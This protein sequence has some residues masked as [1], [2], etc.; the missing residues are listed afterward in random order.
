VLRRLITLGG[1]AA[2]LSVFGCV[3]PLTYP[4]TPTPRSG[5][6]AATMAPQ[7][8][9]PVPP[10]SPS[11]SPP[12]HL[13]PKVLAAPP[14]TTEPTRVLEGEPTSTPTIVPAATR[15][16]RSTANFFAAPS[17]PATPNSSS[18][19]SLLATPGNSLTLAPGLSAISIRQGRTAERVVALTYDAGADR[20]EAADLLAYLEGARV[21]VTFGMT[22]RWAESNPDLLRRIVI[23]GDELMNHS[24][25]HR[26]MTGLS[27][28]APVLDRQD[29]IQ[30][31]ARTESI[32]QSLA[33]ASMKP[34]FR[35]PY[36]DQDETVLRDVAAAGYRYS[37]LW[38][39]DSRGWEG[40]SVTQI[41][42]HCLREARPGAI[43]VLHVGV[44]SKD[45]EATHLIVDGLEALGYR[46]VTVG[47]MVGLTTR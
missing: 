12:T 45:V 36:G 32:V 39:V 30:E 43:Y 41:V 21:K 22:G 6:V 5:V 8:N 42:D 16:P 7:P 38:S 27:S 13:A 19:P 20:G 35:P 33:G 26:S 17:P 47:Q 34:F 40:A 24:Y 29:R 31:I 1:L 9:P 3:A 25:D 28:G 10:P 15:T 37:V 44:N 23:D 46:F 11:T 4:S 18:T 2:A 14:V